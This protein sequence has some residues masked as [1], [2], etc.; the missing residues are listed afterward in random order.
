[1]LSAAPTLSKSDYKSDGLGKCRSQD[2]VEKKKGLEPKREVSDDAMMMM[3][4]VV[5]TMMM[6]VSRSGA[7]GRWH[8]PPPASWMGMM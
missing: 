4:M 7:Q 3:M 1:M 2:L 5:M 6:M 8:I